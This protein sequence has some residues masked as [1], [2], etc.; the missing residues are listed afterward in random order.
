MIEVADVPAAQRPIARPRS[1][2][3]KYGGDDR[4]AARDEDRAERSLEDPRDDQDLHR[5]GEA[6]GDRGGAEADEADAERPPPPV[7]VADRAGQDQERGEHRE[8]RAVDVREAFQPSDEGD[9]QLAA[10]RLERHV[11]DRRVE[12]HDGRSEDRGH[13]D[14]RALAHRPIVAEPEPLPSRGRRSVADEQRRARSAAGDP[15]RRSA[16]ERPPHAPIG[17]AVDRAALLVPRGRRGRF[18]RRGDAQAAP[19]RRPGRAAKAM[20]TTGARRSPDAA[21]REPRWL[22]GFVWVASGRILSLGPWTILT[23]H[24]WAALALIPVVLV[25]LAATPLPAAPA[26]RRRAADQPPHGPRERRPPAASA[27]AWGTS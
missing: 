25:H 22:G 21:R 17:D 24:V 15:A 6:A 13:Q 3:S 8:V 4:E 11:H 27:P 14:G 5:R 19:E 20:G 2:P 1:S 12:E 10:D 18:A 9:R 26:A 16:G 23:L 7:V